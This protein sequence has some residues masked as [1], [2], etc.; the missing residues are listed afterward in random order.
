MSVTALKLP[1]VESPA[2][3][4]RR[5]REEASQEARNHAKM[6]ERAI[7]DLEL[8]A[9]DIAEGG[10]EYPVGVRE[11]ARRLCPELTGARLN[12]GSLLGR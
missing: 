10:E 12:I 11:A 7:Q 1:N 4:I 2:E 8:L 5:L 6:F 9:A 3:K